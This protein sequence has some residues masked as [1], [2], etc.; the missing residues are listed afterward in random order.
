MSSNNDQLN[1][2]NKGK[3]AL[4]QENAE[5]IKVNDSNVKQFQTLQKRNNEYEKL[6]S[7]MTNQVLIQKHENFEKSSQISLLK[8]KMQY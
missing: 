5:L 2:T 4:Q 6:I 3:I 7:E 8:K 1:V